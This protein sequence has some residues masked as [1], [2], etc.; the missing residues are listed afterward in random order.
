MLDELIRRTHELNIRNLDNQ[1]DD[2]LEEGRDRVLIKIL[3]RYKGKKLKSLP[4]IVQE[5]LKEFKNRIDS[6]KIT[7]A[8]FTSPYVQPSTVT[9]TNEQQTNSLHKKF[10]SIT[11]DDLL[12]DYEETTQEIKKQSYKKLIG[13]ILI[14]LIPLIM[15]LSPYLKKP[16][17]LAT[18]YF[19]NLF[20]LLFS[21]IIIFYCNK[22]YSKTPEQM[23]QESIAQYPGKCP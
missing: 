20:Y 17:K 22:I 23:I 21:I 14:S 4:P 15:M 10:E 16:I 19:K 18:I 6:M 2:Y 12:K 8:D 5:E 11:I 1:L 9:H 7:Q 13:T 3:K